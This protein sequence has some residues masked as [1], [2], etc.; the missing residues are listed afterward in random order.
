MKECKWFGRFDKPTQYTLVA[1]ILI[2]VSEIIAI[3]LRI[4]YLQDLGLLYY[5][6]DSNIFSGIAAGAFVY[7]MIKRGKI[8]MWVSYLKYVATLMLTVT[9][10]VVIFVLSPMLPNGYYIFLLSDHMLFTH[11]ICPILGIV[12][13][14]FLEHHI[15]PKAYRWKI[16]IPTGIYAVV[17][18]FLNIIR[19]VDGP[20]PFIMVYNQTVWTTIAYAIGILG[21]AYLI[22]L[23]IYKLKQLYPKTAKPLHYKKKVLKSS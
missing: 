9:F 17:M 7:Y 13:F 8:P 2:V 14:L 3:I 22:S 1:N 16:L 18:L 5:T 11:T 12:S 21:G 19:A 10:L 20:Y 15:L 23:V 6:M 4:L